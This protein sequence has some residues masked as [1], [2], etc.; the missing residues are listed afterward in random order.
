MPLRADFENSEPGSASTSFCVGFVVDDAF[1]SCGHTC[2]LLPCY[3]VTIIISSRIIS[4]KVCFDC[5]I[6]SQQQY[7]KQQANTEIRGDHAR[8]IL[9]PPLPKRQDHRC[10]CWRSNSGLR[11]ALYQLSHISN[12][13]LKLNKQHKMLV[14]TGYVLNYQSNWDHSRELLWSRSGESDTV[15]FSLVLGLYLPD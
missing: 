4:P 7:S 10:A 13:I 12:P 15:L 2:C 3:Q 11:Q 9:L 1:C 14:N 8:L 6:L 5:N